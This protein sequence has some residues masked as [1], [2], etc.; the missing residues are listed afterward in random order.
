M[1]LWTWVEVTGGGVYLQFYINQML[2][3]SLTAVAKSYK[4]VIL[5]LPEYLSTEYFVRQFL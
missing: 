4:A 2:F 3:C 5:Y 1:G